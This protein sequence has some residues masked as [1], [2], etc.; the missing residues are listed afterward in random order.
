MCEIVNLRVTA[1]GSVEKPS[2]ANSPASEEIAAQTASVIFADGV[3]EATVSH[4]DSM[5]SGAQVIGPAIV[6]EYSSTMVVPPGW[7]GEVNE[8]GCVTL[9]KGE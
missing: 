9:R 1:I 7:S 6:E 2:L 8:L 5:P 4:R 3:H